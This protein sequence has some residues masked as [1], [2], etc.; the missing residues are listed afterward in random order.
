MTA[1]G[2]LAVTGAFQAWRGLAAPSDLLGSAY[3]QLLLV[4]LAGV[5]VLVVLGDQGRRHV[6]RIA[7]QRLAVQRLAGGR[8]GRLR[9]IVLAEVAIGLVVLGLTT[10]LVAT[11]TAR[12][13]AE[14]LP[15]L[16]VDASSLTGFPFRAE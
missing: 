16:R 2:V 10:Q 3:G 1:V 14:H 9:G 13:A 6:R 5:A 12:S 15:S 7:V 11:A 4:K 8:P